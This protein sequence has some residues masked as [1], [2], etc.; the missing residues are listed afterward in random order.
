[1]VLC[2]SEICMTTGSLLSPTL[3]HDFHYIIIWSFDMSNK[4]SNMAGFLTNQQAGKFHFLQGTCSRG[5]EKSKLGTG[6]TDNCTVNSSQFWWRY[7]CYWLFMTSIFSICPTQ[8]L[9]KGISRMLLCCSVF[10]V[11]Q[12]VEPWW[13]PGVGAF[14]KQLKQLP[15]LPRCASAKFN[16]PTI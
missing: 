8:L 9:P 10:I 1:M 16:S 12:V 2:K 3:F 11:L 4:T 14:N 6:T 5:P 7:D 13:I 15:F